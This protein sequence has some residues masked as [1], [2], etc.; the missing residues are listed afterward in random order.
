MGYLLSGRPI[1]AYVKNMAKTG[2]HYWVFALVMPI[3]DGFLSIRLKPTSPIMDTV[4]DLYQ[5]LSQLE[6]QPGNEG[7]KGMEAAGAVLGERLS[8]LGFE[9][10][11]DFMAVAL[12]SEI[13]ARE[14]A[15]KADPKPGGEPSLAKELFADLDG[16]IELRALLLTKRKYFDQLG[17]EITKVALNSSVAAARLSEE[18]RALGVI[19]EEVSLVSLK[20]QAEAEKLNSEVELLS[21]ILNG[22]SFLIAFCVLIEEMKCYYR[23]STN[24]SDMNGEQQVAAYGAR[25]ED[26]AGILDQ[27]HD[28]ILSKCIENIQSLRSS[29]VRFERF[30]AALAKV[31]LSLQLGYV[32]GKS[33]SAQIDEG[34]QFTTLLENMK[35]L[36]DEARRELGALEQSVK[37]AKNTVQ[38]WKSASLSATCP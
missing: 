25:F 34:G 5:E 32:T 14:E 23:R 36:S 3:E 20:I 12:R 11:D 6:R 33:L 28:L 38:S 13:K 16:L 29:L 21:G 35:K 7:R 27:N 17:F 4:K 18:G 9:S 22:T 30:N 19:S 8:E 26:L 15:L 2:E 37:S 10:Y 1:G 24:D 31:L